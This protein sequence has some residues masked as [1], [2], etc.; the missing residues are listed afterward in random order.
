MDIFEKIF[1]AEVDDISEEEFVR[2]M[3][4]L[5]QCKTMDQVFMHLV[6]YGIIEDVGTLYT[7]TSGFKTADFPGP[8]D[9]IH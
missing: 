1:D 5:E 6:K 4:E 9:T 7:S 3:D 2:R 8:N